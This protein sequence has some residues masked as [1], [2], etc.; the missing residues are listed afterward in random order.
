MLRTALSS[1]LALSVTLVIAACG[2][3]T[4]LFTYTKPQASDAT[5]IRDREE[6]LR[7]S[8]VTR[9]TIT[10]KADG[11]AILEIEVKEKNQ[12]PGMEAAQRLGYTRVKL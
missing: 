12:A 4:V 7:A 11:S 5:V 9:A 6:M 2:A 3:R 1:I 8:G 10:P